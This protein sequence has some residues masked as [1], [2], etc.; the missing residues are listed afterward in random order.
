MA[1]NLPQPPQKS[2]TKFLL[3]MTL[4]GV[5]ICVALVSMYFPRMISWYFEPPMPMGV[6]CT[7]SIRWAVEQLQMAQIYAILGGAVI[8][9][10]LGLKLRKRT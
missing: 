6:S 10:L 2:S 5:L 8:G 7:S 3:S 4:A 9:L 1:E